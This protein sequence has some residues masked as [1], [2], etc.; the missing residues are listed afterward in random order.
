MSFYPSN[1]ILIYFLV[2]YHTVILP[3][4]E[5]MD[6]SLIFI[7]HNYKSLNTKSKFWIDVS[8]FSL[9]LSW[10]KQHKRIKIVMNNY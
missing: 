1:F 7:S 9:A 8:L 2:I 4:Y 5:S 10:S 3:F 6:L